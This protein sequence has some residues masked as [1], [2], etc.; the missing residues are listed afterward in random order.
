MDAMMAARFVYNILSFCTRYY[1][2]YYLL[3]QRE[4]LKP[5]GIHR[6]GA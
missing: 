3:S 2:Y 5:T 6:R 4:R 1:Y